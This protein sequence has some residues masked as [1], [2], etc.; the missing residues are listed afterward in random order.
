MIMKKLP[1]WL[2]KKLPYNKSFFKIKGLIDKFNI[3]TVCEES[4]CPNIYEC[5]SK[6]T[7]T[8]LSHGKFCTRKCKFCN[9]LY[10]KKPLPLDKNEPNRI[11][12]FAKKLNLKHIIITMVTRDDLEDEGADHLVLIIR[13]IKNKLA[14]SSIEVLSSDFSGKKALLDKILNEDIQVFGHNLE[15]TEELTPKIRYKASYIRS[16]KVL[17]YA[18]SYKNILVKSGIMLGFGETENQVKKSIRDLKKVGCDI[19]TIGQYLQPGKKNIKVKQYIHPSQFKKYED[20]GYSI[21]IKK[22]FSS[23]FIRFSYKN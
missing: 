5:F 14:N 7:A 1:P 17:A 22:I 6:K 10:S 9:I 8:F 23:P 16:L 2:V 20:Y 21:G 12:L 11:A 3:N 19:V 18:K 4:K 13:E 15:T